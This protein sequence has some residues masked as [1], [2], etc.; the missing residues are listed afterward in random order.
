M[1]STRELRSMAMLGF[2]CPPLPML[3]VHE[4]S[5]G[6]VVRS[7]HD[8]IGKFMDICGQRMDAEC[9]RVRLETQDALT[10]WYIRALQE[11]KS[12]GEAYELMTSFT[13]KYMQSYFPGGTQDVRF[14]G[15]DSVPKNVVDS[16]RGWMVG[17]CIMGG[18]RDETVE[19]HKHKGAEEVYRDCV[20]VV[21][22]NPLSIVRYFDED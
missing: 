12:V 19:P 14:V 6:Q 3:M 20:A 7:S 18:A 1:D 5:G 21:K 11:T 2:P 16:A 4:E 8:L 9:D 17:R 15:L 22:R 10:K 13:R